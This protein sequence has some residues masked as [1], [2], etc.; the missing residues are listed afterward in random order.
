MLGLAS[1][2]HG[3]W[4]VYELQ[5]QADEGSSLNFSFYSGAYVVAPLSG[6]AASIV[7]TT[8][9]GGRFYAVSEEAA[10][11]FTVATLNQRRTVISALAV[12]GTAQA[13]Y[14]AGGKV[15]H[16]LTLPGPNGLRSFRVAKELKG[17]LLATDD[18]SDAPALAADGSL[19]MVGAAKIEGRM[20]EDLTLNAVQF[21]SQT[22]VVLY[23]VGLLEHYGYTSDGEELTS[24]DEGAEVV[25]SSDVK[26]SSSGADASLFP[27][28]SAVEP[29]TRAQ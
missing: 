11:L 28:G 21:A 6:G 23:L 17:Q 3:Q 19:G 13:F 18:D 7:L 8:E 5:F 12:N 9:E 10:R 22:D 25:E 29:K 15:N 24:A 1:L 2:A 14:S 4:L 20:R 26:P 27:A 16:T